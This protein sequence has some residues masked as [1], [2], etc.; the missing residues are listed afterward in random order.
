MLSV[1]DG[2]LEYEEGS[3]FLSPRAERGM[4]V[5]YTPADEGE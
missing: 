5:N 2:L 1:F 4:S 3:T